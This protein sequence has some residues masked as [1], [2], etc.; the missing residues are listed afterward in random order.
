MY[1]ENGPKITTHHDYAVLNYYTYFNRSMGLRETE[2]TERRKEGRG[3][4]LITFSSP[5]PSAS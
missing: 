3:E 1:M 5:L 4:Q 2:R